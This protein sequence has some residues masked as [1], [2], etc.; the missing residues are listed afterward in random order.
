VRNFVFAGPFFLILQGFYFQQQSGETPPL[1]SM[2]NMTS[3]LI[4]SGFF[5]HSF[6]SVKISNILRLIFLIFAEELFDMQVFMLIWEGLLA[7]E[8]ILNLLHILSFFFIKAG[9]HGKVIRCLH[10]FYSHPVFTVAIGFH[11]MFVLIRF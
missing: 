2:L 5:F 11:Y 1:V 10:L 8:M 4:C 6:I 9:Y 7:E 3:A